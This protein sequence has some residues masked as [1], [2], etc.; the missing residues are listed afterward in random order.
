MNPPLEELYLTWLY[1]Q[2]GYNGSPS[3]THWSLFKKLHDTEFFWN[4][5]N[6][7]NR[8]E[9]GIQLRY[10]FMDDEDL[11]YVDPEW[12]ELGC[13]VLELLIGLS[14]R[15]SFEAEGEPRVWFWEMLEN[16]GI[17]GLTDRRYTPH[18]EREVEKVLDRLI[19]RRYDN[20]GRG[21]LFP[22]SHPHG[23][24]R[25]VELWVQMNDYILERV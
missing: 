9:D 5:P 21:G 13:S 14:R 16:L 3:R 25:K 24:Q 22:L 6:D 1:R 23:D 8:V 18:A 17:A 15:L 10:E 7:D 11:I 4:V 19:W 20:K 12:L 2:V